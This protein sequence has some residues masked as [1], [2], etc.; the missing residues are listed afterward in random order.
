MKALE[1][2]LSGLDLRG[3]LEAS[4]ALVDA[5]VALYDE[6]RLRYLDWQMCTKRDQELTGEKKDKEWR[7]DAQGVVRERVVSVKSP[8]DTST[9]LRLRFAL[10][11]RGL[12][13]EVAQLMSFDVH[14]LL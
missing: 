11:R 6:N 1:R 3:E 14:E 5:C 10:Q 8:A 7:P 12:A 9:D 13:L 4:H 2:R